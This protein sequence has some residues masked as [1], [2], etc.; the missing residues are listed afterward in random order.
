MKETYSGVTITLGDTQIYGEGWSFTN[1][2]GLSTDLGRNVV[3]L[4]DNG[5]TIEDVGGEN[6][7]FAP[8]FCKDFPT[9]AD[10][11]NA[12][13]TLRAAVKAEGAAELVASLPGLVPATGWLDIFTRPAADIGLYIGGVHITAEDGAVPEEWARAINAADCGVLATAR[14]GSNYIDLQ[15]VQLGTEGNGIT[16]SADVNFCHV[17]GDHLTGGGLG[18]QS[19]TLASSAAVQ[20]MTMSVQPMFYA[21]DAV[22]RLTINYNILTV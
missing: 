6:G 21:G 15:A 14:T 5:A 19:R 13:A 16:L 20:G 18:T 10:A 17:S 4:V 3:K 7:S 2:W 22:I 12:F 11:L 1:A 8:E 9:L